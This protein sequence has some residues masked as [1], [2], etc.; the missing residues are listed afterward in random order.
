MNIEN[1]YDI[2]TDVKCYTNNN[3]YRNMIRLIFKVDSNKSI[4]NSILTKEEIDDESWDEIMYDSDCI[5]KTIDIIFEYTKDNILF[6]E[7]YE[8]AAAHMITTDKSIGQVVLLSYDYYYKYHLC[9]CAFFQSPDSF[10]ERSDC[11]LKLK[12]S[13]TN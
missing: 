7:L 11:Y 2:K 4:D 5:S 13:L 10:N 8:A 12:T 1:I 6:D 3:E 9:L